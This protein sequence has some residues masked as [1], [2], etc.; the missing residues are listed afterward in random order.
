MIVGR[1]KKVQGPYLDKAGIDL[2][3]GGGS[4]LL[5]GD[6]NWYGVGHCAVYSSNSIDYL[7]FHGYDASDKGKAKLRIETLTWGKDGWPGVSATN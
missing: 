3:L 7:I 5:Q 1:S 2:A 6:K 4:I